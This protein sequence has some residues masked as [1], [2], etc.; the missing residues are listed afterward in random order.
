MAHNYPHGM[1]SWD[2][3]ASV[4]S[5]TKVATN[6]T[7]EHAPTHQVK[8]IPSNHHVSEDA[9]PSGTGSKPIPPELVSVLAPM[10]LKA[11]KR[12]P[13][14][15]EDVLKKAAAQRKKLVPPRARLPRRCKSNHSSMSYIE[16]S[17][18][19]LYFDSILYG[20]TVAFR[21]NG[22]ARL[23]VPA[24]VNTT[25]D[26]ASASPLTA[27]SPVESVA[28]GPM[29]KAAATSGQRTTRV[30]AAHVRRKRGGPRKTLATDD[31]GVEPPDTNM[32]RNEE[33]PTPFQRKRRRPWKGK[34]SLTTEDEKIV[35]QNTEIGRNGGETTHSKRNRG[36]PRKEEKSLA[37][38]EDTKM[39]RNVGEP[40]NFK[41]TRDRPRKMLPSPE[42][43][44]L[45]PST[46]TGSNELRLTNTRIDNSS[47]RGP[48][49]TRT[50]HK[51]GQASNAKH[52]RLKGVI[53]LGI[54]RRKQLKMDHV[55]ESGDTAGNTA[56]DDFVV[57]PQN[58]AQQDQHHATSM[59][60]IV[61]AKTTVRPSGSSKSRTSKVRFAPTTTTFSLKIRVKTSGISSRKS[62]RRHS[63][64]PA[65]SQSTVQSI[66]N[67][68]TQA[69]LAQNSEGIAST[70]RG[71][72]DGGDDRSENE[73][74]ASDSYSSDDSENESDD[75]GVEDEVHEVQRS[76]GAL[77]GAA[78]AHD[79]GARQQRE[80][81]ID[82]DYDTRSVASE[83]TMDIDLLRGE[84][85]TDAAKLEPS[86]EEEG[87]SFPHQ[88]DGSFDDDEPK[89][90]LYNDPDANHLI[91]DDLPR[92]KISYSRPANSSND[93]IG[94]SLPERGQRLDIK[95]NWQSNAAL[96]EDKKRYWETERRLEAKTLP[97][98]KRRRL[99][100]TDSLAGDTL[101]SFHSIRSTRG[102]GTTKGR[103]QRGIKSGVLGKVLQKKADNIVD[104]AIVARHLKPVAKAGPR[105]NGYNLESND[106]TV[107]T[108]KPH[109]SK[110]VPAL[111]ATGK[112][113]K[114]SG[115][116]H[117]FDC[118][119]CTR[120]IA[121]LQRGLR[122]GQRTGCL[123][124][125]CKVRSFEK[126]MDTLGR[127][128][129]F[130]GVSTKDET[131]EK[132][133]PRPVA[134]AIGKAADKDD[135][136]VVSHYSETGSLYSTASKQRRSR[137][138]RMWSRRWSKERKKI[139]SGASVSSE[140]KGDSAGTKLGGLAPPKKGQGVVGLQKKGKKTKS[141][142]HDL[143]LPMPTDGSVASVLE[144]RKALRAL[145]TYDEADQDW[146]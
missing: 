102:E 59:R 117:T 109:D 23:S 126:S 68:I 35:E 34:K 116:L 141:A 11:V 78:A 127:P 130:A 30:E 36:R 105:Q 58:D 53:D 81:L 77:R 29:E 146:L 74:E 144:A 76:V 112:C 90:Q 15:H 134:E 84:L 3:L 54:L 96:L 10:G 133:P 137:A 138:A 49:T 140:A 57:G 62:N 83:I 52:S 28:P 17:D 7:R 33:E 56:K 70:D 44:T 4:A 41:R 104:H 121:S 61:K 50:T 13:Q 95:Y 60:P 86:T 106:E 132:R 79:Q 100:S 6:K 136:D 19:D 110:C 21:N 122:F 55:D 47:L 26:D 63:A 12:L 39:G 123:R 24:E 88:D 108:D 145:M 67:Q 111:A 71:H 75:D 73:D 16:E 40:T 8:N 2:S 87:P 80:V 131:G 119:T 93:K 9:S 114:C 22:E 98:R 66:A 42:W 97:E 27:A 5:V 45:L 139:S 48:S 69:Y 31:E 64:P 99:T 107:V 89:V 38:E 120:C 51:R 91:E 46:A 115:C 128:L 82:R 85:E 124:R 103:H 37:T 43:E 72:E 135:D 113:G 1:K 18:D 25:R 125:I 14:T 32:G 94:Q 143:E 20:D 129:K 101:A 92:K 118:L 65:L 142:L